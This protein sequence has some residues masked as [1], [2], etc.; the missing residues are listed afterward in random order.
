MET[1]QEVAEFDELV[2]GPPL[3]VGVHSVATRPDGQRKAVSSLIEVRDPEAA[4]VARTARPGDRVRLTIV[5][6]WDDPD[7]PTWVTGFEI[8]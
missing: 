1:L 3:Q 2:E 6:D 4:R 8:L 5:T 7:I